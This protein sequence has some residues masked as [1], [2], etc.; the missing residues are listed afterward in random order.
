[1]VS[2]NPQNQS[3]SFQTPPSADLLNAFEIA[4]LV[5]DDGVSVDHLMCYFADELQ[6]QGRRIGGV[7]QLPPE[8]EGMPSTEMR[9]MDLM[10]G[11]IISIQQNLGRGSGACKLDPGGLMVAATRI[12]RAIEAGVD[13]MFISKF[14]KQEVAG[15]GFRDEFGLAVGAGIPILTSVKRPLVNDW[16]NFTG[17]IGTLLACRLRVTRDWW[18][19]TDTRRCKL[20]ARQ[21][22]EVRL[23]ESRATP[24]VPL[25]ATVP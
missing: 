24:V 2:P 3:D 5:Y 25:F 23:L 20:L 22:E 7:V 1:M 18:E 16:L 21:Q 19:E 12:R 10:T 9:V 13:L 6:H 4:A 11:E 17:G 14:S 15:H 8:V